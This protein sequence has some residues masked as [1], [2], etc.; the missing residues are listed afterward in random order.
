MTPLFPI[1]ATLRVWLSDSRV[2]SLYRLR[3]PEA[4]RVGHSV[5]SQFPVDPHAL[6]GALAR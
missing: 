3:A 2:A 6:H 5:D 4:S 1:A